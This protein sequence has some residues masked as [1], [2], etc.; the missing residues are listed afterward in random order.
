MNIIN[1]EI[2]TAGKFRYWV[3]CEDG[4]VTMLK[5]DEV[6]SDELVKQEMQRILNNQVTEEI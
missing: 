6:T 5:F 1:Q 2:D 4:S 3:Q